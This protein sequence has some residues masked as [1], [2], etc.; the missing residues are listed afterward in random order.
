M[1][2]A[3]L[4][5][6]LGELK[7]WGLDGNSIMKEYEFKDFKEAIGFV[8][9]VADVCEKNEHHPDIMINYNIVRLTLTTHKENGLTDID[10]KVAKEI[11]L[12]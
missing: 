6:R 12:I 1:N 7:D 8:N 2:L 10:F 11:D 5:A 9:K 4:Q 3:Q